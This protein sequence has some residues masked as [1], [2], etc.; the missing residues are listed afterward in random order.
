MSTESVL[1]TTD[2]DAYDNLDVV[3][4]DVPCSFLNADIDEE[5]ILLLEVDIAEIMESISPSTYREY[6]S[7]GNNVRKILYVKV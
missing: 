5:V 4:V 1:I 7:V 6:A 2:I 3:I